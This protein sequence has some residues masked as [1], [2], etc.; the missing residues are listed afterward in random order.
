[1]DGFGERFSRA[2]LMKEPIN[3][4]YMAE[5]AVRL[6]RAAGVISGPRYYSMPTEERGPATTEKDA[7]SS[8][9]ATRKLSGPPIIRCV[10]MMAASK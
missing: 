4:P 9:L 8:P 3:M 2:I 10:I 6:N 5:R 7:E 1:M